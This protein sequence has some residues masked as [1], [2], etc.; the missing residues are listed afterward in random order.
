MANIYSPNGTYNQAFLKNYADIYLLDKIQRIDGVGSVNTFGS[1]YAMRVWLNPQKVAQRGLTASEV[2]RAIREQNVQVAAGVIGA[3][4][5]QPRTPSV[6]KY[7]LDIFPSH[8]LFHDFSIMP[9]GRAA[10]L[11]PPPSTRAKHHASQQHRESE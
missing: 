1:S 3:S 9:Q 6:P 5:T 8:R 10:C 7:F 2:V 11:P 4:P